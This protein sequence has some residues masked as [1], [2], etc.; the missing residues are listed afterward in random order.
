[1]FLP[2]VWFSVTSLV[3]SV[4]TESTVDAADGFSCAEGENGLST[5]GVSKVA[6]ELSEMPK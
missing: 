5:P 6:G 1:M 4:V 2:S 3:L